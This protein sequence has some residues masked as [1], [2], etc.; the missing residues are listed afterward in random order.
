M[1]S[2][3]FSDLVDSYLDLKWHIDPVEA[4]GAGL[5][6][7]DGRYGDYQAEEI[8]RSLAALRSLESALEAVATDS[9]TDEVD[10]TALLNDLRVTVNRFKKER[11]HE[12]N[13]LFWVS[14]ALDGLYLLLAQRDRTIEH[15]NRT[16][17]ERL[18]S[19]PGLLASAKATLSR[20][21]AVLT[22]AAVAVTESGVSLVDDV[23]A[24]LIE[25]GDADG[26][27]AGTMAREAL[28]AFSDDLRQRLEEG[29]GVGI[30]I[31]E[32][33]FNFRLHFQHALK[34]NAPQLWRFGLRLIE[35]TERE[36][37]RVAA[38]ID[39]AVAWP[40]LADRLRREHGASQGLVAAYTAEMERSH[41]FVEDHDLIAVP[42]GK[43]EVVE[44]PG[45]LRNVIP[46]AAY[47]PPGAFSEDRTG[48]FYVTPP[49]RTA[50]GKGSQR[51]FTGGCVHE[52]PGVAAHEGYPGHHLQFLCAHAQ[53]RVIRKIVM[54]PLTVEG[55]AMYSEQMMLESGFYRR[56]EEEFFQQV[57]ALWRAARVVID[58]GLH[59]RGMTFRE[60]VGLLVEKVHFDHALAEAE[61][62]RYCAYPAYQLCY[63]VG[64]SELMA[65]RDDYR[66]AV[67]AGYTPREFH[68]KVMEYGGLP[69]SLMR[70][71]MGLGD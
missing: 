41:S 37:A 15:R 22:E 50:E 49:D 70:W 24:A 17:G 14:H 23:A 71:G 26:S 64:A 62:R 69:V 28:T 42:E 52:L 5:A 55:W 66:K 51:Q 43:L 60:A 40:E 33:A 27:S 39:S 12:R 44:T 21:P 65:L 11:P 68:A 1:T 46:F 4:T 31:G 48:C 35:R 45:Y 32:D 6:Q 38:E 67:G 9:L 57:A 16:L 7:H 3:A 13:P 61:V 47:Q 34:A 30:G 63:A 10:R 8:K 56:L 53:P 18:K 59:T 58:V 36:V 20:C 2:G 29:D 19:L 25:S 54:T